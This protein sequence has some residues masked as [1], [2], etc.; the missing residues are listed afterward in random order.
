MASA[1]DLR[2]AYANI[3]AQAAE[4]AD[5]WPHASNVSDLCVDGRPPRFADATGPI[6]IY[7]MLHRNAEACAMLAACKLEFE[8]FIA[9]IEAVLNPTQVREL[10]ALLLWAS[11]SSWHTCVSVFQEHPSML[12]DEDKARWRK[13]TDADAK[14]LAAA[15]RERYAALEP[16]QLALDTLIV[17]ADG[18]LIAGFLET[19]YLA[20]FGALR[21]ASTEVG[22]AVL[23]ELTSRPKRLIHVTLGRLLGVPASLSAVQRAA[24]ASAVKTFNAGRRR[25]VAAATPITLP[26]VSLARDD[27]W[28][29]TEYTELARLPLGVPAEESR[30]RERRGAGPCKK[31]A[32][33]AAVLVG[34]LASLAALA[35]PRTAAALDGVPVRGTLTLGSWEP[36]EPPPR[37]AE[38]LHFR[39]AAAALAALPCVEHWTAAHLQRHRG[40]AP[41]SVWRSSSA[42]GRTMPPSFEFVLARGREAEYPRSRG[43][44]GTNMTLATFFAALD[45]DDAR[46]RPPT[47]HGL[48]YHTSPLARWPEALRAEAEA[49]ERMFGVDDA[50]SASSAADWPAPSSNLWLGQRGVVAA[51]HYDS[52]HNYVLQVFGRKTWALWPPDALPALRL[53]PA[54][55]PS[56]RQTRLQ[57][58]GRGNAS[59]APPLPPAVRVTV[60]AGEVLYVPPFWAHAV[61][62]DTHSLSL[63]VLSPSWEEATFARVK[64]APLPFGRVPT[65]NGGGEA[66]AVAAAAL[67]H[68]LLGRTDALRGEAPA[69]FVASVHAA[70][71]AALPLDPPPDAA[72]AAAAGVTPLAC[73]V[74]AA[75]APA[76]VLDELFSR[77][78]ALADT[79]AA[80]SEVLRTR[81]G[82]G[83]FDDA[84]ARELL[85]GYVEELAAWAV[86]ADAAPELL[87]CWGGL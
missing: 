52:S 21:S 24:V 55:H 49:A 48:L 7:A 23:G 67:L 68:E 74:L 11:P 87:R 79:A 32:F 40:G 9:L 81:D 59:E 35:Q 1:A 86:G 62:S 2:S 73:S 27:V 84:V 75:G 39:P 83:A 63:S 70:R 56:R 25:P 44:R 10:R 16:P 41:L 4:Q 80:A 46:A 34:G 8:A 14:A 71:H 43:V 13:V 29:M 72:A 65:G 69:A 12:S 61:H 19:S 26:E 22:A 45:A 30:K 57:L 38:P 47:T 78:Q 85:A 28:F 77:P 76:A 33:V 82:I 53:H 51:A 58:V 54:T 66:R 18:A 3:R 36:P 15:L 42:D 20:P 60:A 6:G 50:P 37:A 31:M 17:C 64:N 5:G